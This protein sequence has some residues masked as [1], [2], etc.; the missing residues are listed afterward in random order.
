ML[1]Y[2]VLRIIL[3]I[4]LVSFKQHGQ[5]MFIY[6]MGECDVVNKNPE[7]KIDYDKSILFS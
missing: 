1:R 4:F 3:C 2:D 7:R 5:D 6:W